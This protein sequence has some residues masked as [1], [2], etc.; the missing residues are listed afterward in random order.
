MIDIIIPTYNSNKSLIGTLYSII[1][2]TIRDKLKVYIIDDCS[3]EDYND[4]YNL[5]S[6]YI[7][8]KILRMPKNG[9][10]GVARQYGLDNSDGDYV[11]FIDSDDVFYEITSV[12]II[13]NAI[14]GYD[15]VFG[16]MYDEKNDRYSRHEGCLHGK[17]YKRSFLKD[18]NIRFNTLR[19]HEDNA[20]NQICLAT[21]KIKFIDDVIY[22]YKYNDK[23]LT[24]NEDDVESMNTYIKSMNSALEKIDSFRKLNFTNVSVYVLTTVLYLYYN[25]L[26]NQEKYNFI[27]DKAS[28]I[29]KMYYKYIG[30]LNENDYIKIYKNFNYNIV[31]N[32]TIEEFL[33][34]IK[35]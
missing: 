16:Q 19:S 6:K 28:F 15:M 33:N 23:S 29:K 24:N 2:Q 27:F 13:Y 17:M 18:N 8:L 22:V 14:I 5:F 10:P 35:E 7:D 1:N 32:M 9:G 3:N 26:C 4:I 12:E 31:P 11:I 34:K 25:Y 21:A 20:F 30:Y